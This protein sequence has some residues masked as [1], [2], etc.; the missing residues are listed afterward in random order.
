MRLN[1]QHLKRCLKKK[2]PNIIDTS[3]ALDN[4]VVP[5]KTKRSKV[6]LKGRNHT[7]KLRIKDDPPNSA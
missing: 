1:S 3:L 2:T 7:K 4:P 6:V 5:A